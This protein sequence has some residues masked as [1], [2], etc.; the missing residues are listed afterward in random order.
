MLIDVYIY[1]Y[2]D[3]LLDVFV[4]WCMYSCV[5]VF[6]RLCV[7]VFMFLWKPINVYLWFC[8]NVV[9]WNCVNPLSSL[10]VPFVIHSYVHMILFARSLRA[11][12]QDAIPFIPYLLLAYNSGLPYKRTDKV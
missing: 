8:G 12:G 5:Y 7:D 4:C 3:L 6:M 9:L 11:E 1:M 2:V 10:S